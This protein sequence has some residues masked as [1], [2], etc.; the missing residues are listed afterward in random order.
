MV[1]PVR[2]TGILDLTILEILEV[3]DLVMRDVMDR[4]DSES[5]HVTRGAAKSAILGLKEKVY[6]AEDGV[7]FD[8][9]GRI[10]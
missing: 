5:G 3:E 1:C 8:L 7:L 4:L 6:A 10:S 9:S 2:M